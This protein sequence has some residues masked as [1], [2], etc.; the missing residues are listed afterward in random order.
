[1][2]F[3]FAGSRRVLTT[4]V[5]D[6]SRKPFLLALSASLRPSKIIRNG[7]RADPINLLSHTQKFK[8]APTFLVISL[9]EVR[10]FFLQ[11]IVRLKDVKTQRS[12]ILCFVR[13]LCFYLRSL[14]F[15]WSSPKKPI[16]H[17][18]FVDQRLKH[19]P[20]IFKPTLRSLV[21]WLG[22]LALTTG[23]LRLKI[24]GCIVFATSI[25]SILNPFKLFE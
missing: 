2:Q 21:F 1:M 17:H 7:R 11:V 16:H 6:W 20:K 8:L 5:D 15:N 25:H 10:S 22:T 18:R 4:V 3:L 14:C 24:G 9:P 13:D 12:K 23:S 19:P